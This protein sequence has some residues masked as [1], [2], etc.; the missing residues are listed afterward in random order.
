MYETVE[1]LSYN[2]E[3]LGRRREPEEMHIYPEPRT[4]GKPGKLEPI[5]VTACT[6]LPGQPEYDVPGTELLHTANISNIGVWVAC[7]IARENVTK[8]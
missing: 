2:E 5:I 7:K 1:L 3:V 8:E 4:Q 6:I